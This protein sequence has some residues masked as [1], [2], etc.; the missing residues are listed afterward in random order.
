MANNWNSTE[1]GSKMCIYIEAT[2]KVW[3]VASKWK[4]MECTNLVYLTSINKSII[5]QERP[6]VTSLFGHIAHIIIKQVEKRHKLSSQCFQDV[7]TL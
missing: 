3:H 5:S 2:E 6:C 7:K 4:A 1:F